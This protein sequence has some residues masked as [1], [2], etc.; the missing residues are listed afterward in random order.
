MSQDPH[1]RELDELE[2]EVERLQSSDEIDKSSE[3]DKPKPESKT[4]EDDKTYE[5]NTKEEWKRNDRE[6]NTRL[7]YDDTEIEIEEI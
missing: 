5:E 7:T 3:G 2:K 6:K 4:I 1:K